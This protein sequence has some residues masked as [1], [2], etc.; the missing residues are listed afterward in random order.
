MAGVP[1]LLFRLRSLL[2]EEGVR[3]MFTPRYSRRS[4]TKSGD[5]Y[6]VQQPDP[7]GSDPRHPGEESD[8][9][10]PSKKN[11]GLLGIGVTS[12]GPVNLKFPSRVRKGWVWGSRPGL[13]AHVPIHT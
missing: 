6:T 10:P 9:R 12:P 13:I 11:G 4:D 3:F 5:G 2:S 8:P 7:R 1:D